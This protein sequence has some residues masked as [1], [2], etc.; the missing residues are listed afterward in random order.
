MCDHCL[1][2]P[3]RAGSFSDSSSYGHCD[4]NSIVREYTSVTIGGM[5]G[6]VDIRAMTGGMSG[7]LHYHLWFPHLR[8]RTEYLKL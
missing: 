8:W 1:A 4:E 5:G 6:R 2:K 7:T 3:L